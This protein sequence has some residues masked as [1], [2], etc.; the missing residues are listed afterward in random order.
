MD[1]HNENRKEPVVE[2]N[3]EPEEFSFPSGY[4]RA[5]R[6]FPVTK[7]L[8]ISILLLVA[9][10]LAFGLWT[11]FH[12]GA[13]SGKKQPLPPELTALRTEVQ[14]LKSEIDP[15]KNEIQF[16]KDEQKGFQDRTKVLQEQIT[17]LKG[18]LNGLT[19]KSNSQGNKK[20]ASK[21][22]VYKVRKGDTLKTIA[23]RF[24]VKQYD[25]S[26]WNRL[27]PKGKLKPGQT[28]TIYTPTP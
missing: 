5:R 10:G 1:Q 20:P 4:Q 18:Q 16:L 27:P 26:R 2:V 21:V 9:I 17:F 24:R 12:S 8:L 3:H 19:V 28:M 22:I 14:T 15:L 7:W 23:K 13:F 25:L 11:I 6:S